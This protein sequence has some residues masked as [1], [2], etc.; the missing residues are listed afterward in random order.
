M[1]V[2]ILSFAKVLFAAGCGV[3][4][5]V[6]TV[7]RLLLSHHS[8]SVAMGFRAARILPSRVSLPS[9]PQLHELSLRLGDP[10]FG[11]SVESVASAFHFVL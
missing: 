1:Q 2:N 9:S 3:R 6:S 8:S 10:N 7:V 11:H 5:A 4:T